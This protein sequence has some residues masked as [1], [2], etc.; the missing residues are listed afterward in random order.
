[1]DERRTKS[2]TALDR[3]NQIFERYQY[4]LE[5]LQKCEIIHTGD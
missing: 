1:M 4:S 3:C 2:K 5:L